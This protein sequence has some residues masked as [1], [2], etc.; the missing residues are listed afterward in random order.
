MHYFDW[1]RANIPWIASIATVAASFMA[2]AGLLLTWHSISRGT[3]VADANTLFQISRELREAEQRLRSGPLPEV[4]LNNYFNL[5]E[6]F[7]SSIKHRLLGPTSTKIA[8]QRLIL[9]LAI[10]ENNEHT[11]SRLQMAIQ[12]PETFSALTAF[13]KR[14]RQAIRAHAKALLSSSSSNA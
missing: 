11:K 4:E 2:A 12:S 7:A 10:I 9:D 8:I 14:N 6:I 13:A 5:L 3:K 1:L